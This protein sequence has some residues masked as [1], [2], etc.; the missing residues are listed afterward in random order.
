MT[1]LFSLH[2]HMAVDPNCRARAPGDVLRYDY[3]EPGALTVAQLARKTGIPSQVIHGLMAGARGIEAPIAL[4]LA[5]VLDTSAFYWLALQGHYRLEREL[6]QR[7]IALD[8]RVSLAQA[9]ELI[10]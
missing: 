10:G 9:G 1:T 8:Q 4:R 7:Q 5:A 3:L 6:R 2:P